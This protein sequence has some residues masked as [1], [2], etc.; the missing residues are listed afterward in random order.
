[1]WVALHD[2]PSYVSWSFQNYLYGLP[3]SWWIFAVARPIGFEF[4]IEL[5]DPMR[6]FYGAKAPQM[7][8]FLEILALPTACALCVVLQLFSCMM[9]LWLSACTHLQ[10]C[11]R[12]T[13]DDSLSLPVYE[14]VVRWVLPYFVFK[15][16]CFFA[17]CLSKQF[18][19]TFRN[20]S[21]STSRGVATVTTM[22]IQFP[23]CCSIRDPHDCGIR[24]WKHGEPVVN[25][26]NFNKANIMPFC[27]LPLQVSCRESRRTTGQQELHQ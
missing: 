10:Y 24:E 22:V 13:D 17:E 12:P 11:C 5:L 9:R 23:H 7:R 4:G 14:A 19:V 15:R 27:F 16:A 20:Q 1:M 18:L 8:D 21:I 2:G 6:L 25:A 3:L 26:E